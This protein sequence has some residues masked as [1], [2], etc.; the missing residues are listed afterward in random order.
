M[1]YEH[2]LQPF[3]N[4]KVSNESSQALASYT[5]HKVEGT[6]KK[7]HQNNPS[8]FHRITKGMERERERENDVLYAYTD[9]E[10]RQYR[11]ILRGI[12]LRQH[13]AKIFER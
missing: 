4:L 10:R 6:R 8:G 5:H 12:P 1:H 2:I 11:I 7:K 9:R 3:Y 13:D